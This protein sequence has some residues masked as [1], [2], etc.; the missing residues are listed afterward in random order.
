MSSGAHLGLGLCFAAPEGRG[1]EA[2]R[3]P[4]I[5]LHFDGA[6]MEL[7]RE[8]VVVEDRASGVACLGMVSARG[9]SVLGS[10]QQQNMHILYDI[11]RG[12]LCF[13]PDNCAEILDKKNSASSD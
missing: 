13:E 4:R 3:V 9:M 12:V 2:V 10:M 5:V 1:P 6:D 8:S 11:E 7:S